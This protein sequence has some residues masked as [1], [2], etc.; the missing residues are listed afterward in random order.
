VKIHITPWRVTV[1]LAILTALF[2][3]S[4]AV[5]S[6]AASATGFVRL[7]NLSEAHTPVDIYFFPAGT[8][9]PTSPTLADVAYGTVQPSFSA[10]QAGTYTVQIRDAG[11]AA[12]STPFASLSVAVKAGQSYTVAPLQVTGAG[13][14]RQVVAIQDP[15][16][17][18]AGVAFV[19]V[20]NA[21]AKQGS[22]TFHCSCAPGA[23]GDIQTDAKAGTVTTGKI[24]GGDW[25]MTAT[26]SSPSATGSTTFNLTADTSR[27]EI[28]LDNGSSLEVV[29]LLDGTGSVA[30]VGGIGTG[31]GGTAPHG[32]GSPLPWLAIIGAGV[33]LVAG[34]GLGLTRTR[35]IRAK[36]GRSASQG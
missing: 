34:G 25:T 11:A 1:L 10:V 22:I 31:F 18:P 13:S 15:L 17:P 3:F 8:A 29:N 28:V 14:Q 7:G 16:G 33:L 12:S 24:P 2:T 5:P 9:T 21:A 30:A 35:L 27:T 36:L 19:T 26:G 6:N 32:P 4:A 23:P 20:I